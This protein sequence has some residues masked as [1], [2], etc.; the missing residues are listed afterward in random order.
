MLMLKHLT[1]L[2]GTSYCG[3]FLDLE[4]HVVHPCH[5][6]IL[7]ALDCPWRPILPQNNVPICFCLMGNVCLPKTHLH[8]AKCFLTSVVSLLQIFQHH[9]PLADFL[10][11]VPAL[12]QVSHSQGSLL[13]HCNTDLGSPRNSLGVSQHPE[14]YLCRWD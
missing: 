7:A 5:C 9:S 1:L 4:E 14:I 6:R 10:F 12:I 13:L 3:I 11:I 2:W 8:S